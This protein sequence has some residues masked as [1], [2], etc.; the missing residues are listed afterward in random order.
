MRILLMLLL[1]DAGSTSAMNPQ[2]HFRHSVGFKRFKTV[3]RHAG[4]TAVWLTIG[5]A[6]ASAADPGLSERIIQKSREAEEQ[7]SGFFHDTWNRVWNS[8]ESSA[9]RGRSLAVVS[10][11]LRERD[12]AYLLR[13]HMPRHDVTQA[14]VELIGDGLLRIR[15]PASGDAGAYEQNLALT[16]AARQAKPQIE[17][18]SARHLMIVTVAKAT[19][20]GATTDKSAPELAAEPP[21]T[22]LPMPETD[23]DRR[24]LERMKMM[25]RDMDRMMD[26]AYQEFRDMPGARR[27]SGSQSFAASSELREENGRFVVRSYIPESLADKAKV[28][29]EGRVLCIESSGV[30]TTESE[31]SGGMQTARH[32]EWITLPEPVNSARMTVERKQGMLLITIPKADG[33]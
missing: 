28:T 26:R 11:N 12:D 16:A 17:T 25:R 33:V 2:L 14:S 5:S 27:F 23:W 31:K 6:I 9:Q 3:A 20:S 10:T 30:T 21:A 8:N 13:V 24:M 7:M 18:Q 1:S 32:I 19:G 15:V 29:L 4:I 22:P